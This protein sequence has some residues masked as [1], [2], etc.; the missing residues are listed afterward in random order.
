MA[1]VARRAAVVNDL[2]RDWISWAV[3]SGLTAIA[4]A[5]MTRNDAPLSV[6][7][8]WRP[9][10]MMDLAGAAGVRARA[11]VKRLFPYRLVLIVERPRA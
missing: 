9:R 1:R 4:G 8:G 3:I 7:R 10:E 6:L 2:T 11:R 5:P